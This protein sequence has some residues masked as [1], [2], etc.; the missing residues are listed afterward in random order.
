MGGRSLGRAVGVT[1]KTA[2]FMNHRIRLAMAI[3]TFQK[4][5]GTAET[6]ETY[7]GGL[8]RGGPVVA[9]VLD[10]VSAKTVQASIREWVESGSTV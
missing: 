7:I 10:K 4:L 3:G 8:E 1:Q 5:S 2:W 9:T 6:D